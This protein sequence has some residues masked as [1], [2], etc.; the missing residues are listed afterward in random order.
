M[1]MSLCSPGATYMKYSNYSWKILAEDRSQYYFIEGWLKKLKVGNIESYGDL[2]V[3]GCG[4][5]YVLKKYPDALENIRALSSYRKVALVV[6]VDA[7][8]EQVENLL[9]KMPCAT[10][11]PVFFVIPKWSLETWIRFMSNPDD[12]KANDES[13][14]CRETYHYSTKFGREGRNLAGWDFKRI[15]AGPASLKA[16]AIGIKRKKE[17][18]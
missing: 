6:V 7:D 10:N 15:L 13:S 8:N 14:S 2:P 12:P 9:R 1:R 17:S 3:D 11:D 5:A 18:L 4:K 16:C